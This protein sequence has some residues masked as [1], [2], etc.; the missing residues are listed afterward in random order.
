[1][2]N[3]DLA[4]EFHRLVHPGLG[5]DAGKPVLDGG[6]ESAIFLYMLLRNQ[7]DRN[8]AA[9]GVSDGGAEVLLTLKHTR[10]VVAQ[11]PMP[12][13]CIVTLGRI[14]P[15]MDGLII[16]GLAAPLLSG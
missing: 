5:V 16:G 13:V 11:G 3:L 6:D 7:P 12:K 4:R 2:S 1:L 15:I 8:L 9:I 10:G 14:E